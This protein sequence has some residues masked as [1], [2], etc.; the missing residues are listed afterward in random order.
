MMILETRSE[1]KVIVT[2]GWYVTLYHPKIHA[3]TKSWIPTSNNEIEF[4]IKRAL[5]RS[6]E[7]DWSVEWNHLCNFGWV[8]HEELYVPFLLIWYTTWH[9][10]FRFF[11]YFFG[12][13]QGPRM[14]VSTE[15][16]CMVLYDPFQIIWYAT[17]LL[18]GKKMFWHLTPP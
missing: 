6:P 16:A 3:H 5:G 12:P 13:T 17:R 14:C 18:S 9:S 11:L 15:R 7:N 4:W 10:I 1:V 8:H 2:Q